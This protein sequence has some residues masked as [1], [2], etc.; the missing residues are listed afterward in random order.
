MITESELDTLLLDYITRK[1][2]IEVDSPRYR[3]MLDELISVTDK[4]SR[5]AAELW[6]QSQ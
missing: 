1:T 5:L 6:I 4:A 2:T 3:R